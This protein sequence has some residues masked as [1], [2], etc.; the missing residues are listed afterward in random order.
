MAIPIVATPTYELKLP[1]NKKKI[2]YRPFIVKEE[3]LLLLA[4]ETKDPAQIQ[5]TTKQVIKD[6][7]FGE[8]DVETCPPF[9][10]EYI[11]LQ[12]RIRSVGEKASVSLKCSSCN[13]SNPVEID[14]TT[15]DITNNQEHTNDIKLTD[16][17]GV[18]MRYPT[19]LDSASY[20]GAD[21]SKGEEDKVKTAVQSINL[22]A[23]CIEVIYDKDKIYKTKD[24]TKEE[25]IDFI[26][27]LSQGMFQKIASFFENMPA[28][29]HTVEY[30][31]HKCETENKINMRGI[32]DFFT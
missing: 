32:Q 30:K 23:S 27:N 18:M 7:T 31:C 2:K 8:V 13:V 4:M 28:L 25:V 16:T 11:L 20:E 29:R 12:L 3:K 21:P 9:D 10:L 5:N 1:S 22:I 6:C 17:L 24:F 26:E 14:L 15:I 19:M